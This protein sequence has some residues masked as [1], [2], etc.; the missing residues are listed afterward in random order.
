M[1]Q[2]KKG[3]ILSRFGAGAAI[4]ICGSAGPK[5]E[6]ELKEIISAPQHFRTQNDVIEV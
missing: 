5:T 1:S 3:T 6:P 2:V 4:R